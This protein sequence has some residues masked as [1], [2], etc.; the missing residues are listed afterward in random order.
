MRLCAGDPY[1]KRK[2]YQFLCFLICTSWPPHPLFARPTPPQDPTVTETRGGGGGTG[3]SNSSG[4]DE[5]R[6]WPCLT[7]PVQRHFAGLPEVPL[8][9]L[10]C[11]PFISGGHWRVSTTLASPCRGPSACRWPGCTGSKR[12]AFG[13]PRP[14]PGACRLSRGRRAPTLLS[15][16][17][18]RP[19][20]RPPRGRLSSQLALQLFWGLT[21]VHHAPRCGRHGASSHSVLCGSPPCV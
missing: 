1:W 20:P 8:G 5:I 19:F 17:A 21:A 7:P 16:L 14:A 2:F 15:A 4:H 9:T 11:S 12:A 6:A 13:R 10:L 3:I 18:R